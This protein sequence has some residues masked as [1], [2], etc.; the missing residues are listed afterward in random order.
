MEIKDL[1]IVLNEALKSP[2]D[3]KLRTSYGD[4]ITDYLKE[5]KSSDEILSVVI[6]GIDLDRAANY[7]D[8]LESAS[9][10]DLQSVWKQIRQNK[11]IKGAGDGA[12][13]LLAGMLSMAFLKA[14]NMD[15]QCGNIITLLVSL[16]DDSK[17]ALS[18]KTYGP[19]LTDYLLDELDPK[20]PLLKWD[21]IKASDEVKKQFSEILLTITDGENA[22]RYK[23]VRQ[24][25]S[26][27]IRFAD[28]QI[29]KKSI[30]AKIPKSR[31]ADLMELAEHFRSVE[32]QVREGV[33]EVARLEDEITDLHKQIEILHG[34]KCEL[35]GTIKTLHS[36]IEAKQQLL[37][38]AEHEVGE[39]TA[40]N[41]AF[42]AL[43]KNDETALLQDIANELKADYQDLV[44]TE[45]DPMDIE[46]GEIY[47]EK[48]KNVFKILSK[49][50]ITVE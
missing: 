31:V 27:G 50:G 45:S 44:E 13:K 36:E 33:Y 4:A 20:I 46:L 43:K 39:R 32:N 25:A 48:L 35:E 49:K 2:E 38:K 30:E 12:I 22:E 42:S 1:E 29:K 8:Y 15:S 6:R 9:K 18:V 21:S 7:F 11:E 23:A 28:E 5:H 24:W 26:R 10:N 41:E 47:R 19:V 14:G 16:V 3:D 40:I 37:D 34:E 17:G